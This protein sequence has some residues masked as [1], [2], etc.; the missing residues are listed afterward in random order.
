MS[1]PEGRRRWLIWLI[2]LFVLVDIGVAM[3][4]GITIWQNSLPDAPRTDVAAMPENAENM[5]E[6]QIAQWRTMS[7]GD[8]HR[9]VSLYSE[10]EVQRG[11]VQIMLSNA[12]ANQ[13]SVRMDLIRLDNQQL[14]AR[15]DLVD[16][17]W[18]VETVKLLN[19]LEKGTH[20]CLAKLYFYQ[21]DGISLLGETA[22]QVLLRLD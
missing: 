2:V 7:L 19:K 9:L 6:R 3:W 17:G 1:A 10:P 18:R 12:E 22:R 15:T 13:Y 16:P 11:S 5:T 14:I 8:A 21:Q 20:Y 4:L